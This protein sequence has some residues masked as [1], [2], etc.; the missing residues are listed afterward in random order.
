MI[1]VVCYYADLGR[2]YQPLIERMCASARQ[3]LPGARLLMLTPTPRAF[4]YPLF[5]MV[6][7]LPQPADDTNLCLERARSSCSW[8]LVTERPFLLA[9]PDIVFLRPPRI[10]DGADIQ[11]LCR[12]GKPD[13][14]I[15]SGVVYSKPGQADFWKRYGN[16]AINLPWRTHGW[17][18][19]QLAYNLMVGVYHVAGDTVQL[20][21]S[22]VKLVNAYDHC[23][24][25]ERVTERAWAHHLKGSTKGQE[26]AKFYQVRP[27]SGDGRP[28]AAYASSMAGAAAPSSAS[29]PAASP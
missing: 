12:P 25:P 21:P 1:D 8:G 29:Q 10:E 2:P 17:F 18:C 6:L 27:K 14:P 9:D 13:Q 19:D 15:N 20:G 4:M 11:L 7:P 22:C 23:E 16:I 28:S 5:D 26:F 24:R 3:N